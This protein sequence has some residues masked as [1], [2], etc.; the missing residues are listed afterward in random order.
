MEY[1]RP[2]ALTCK[3]KPL[4]IKIDPK[5]GPLA[6]ESMAK[7]EAA[8]TDE[9]YLTQSKFS[10]ADVLMFQVLFTKKH[11]QWIQITVQTVND[12]FSHPYFQHVWKN[13]VSE[14][15]KNVQ[16]WKSHIHTL[17]QDDSVTPQKINKDVMKTIK[18]DYQL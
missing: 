18:S 7:L 10:D 16:R 8:L 14:N 13:D 3:N 15:L 1:M 17:L 6:P 9:S 11:P 2:R 4:N 12:P 5:L